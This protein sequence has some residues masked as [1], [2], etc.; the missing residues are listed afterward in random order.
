LIGIRIQCLLV[1]GVPVKLNIAIVII[2]RHD[3]LLS[4]NHIGGHRGLKPKRIQIVER[5]LPE[6]PGM[7]AASTVIEE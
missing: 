2:R 7:V 5:S 6:Q 3:A 4:R 1:E